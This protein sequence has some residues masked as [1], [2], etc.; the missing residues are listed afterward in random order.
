VSVAEADDVIEITD[1]RIEHGDYPEA[2]LRAI[3]DLERLAIRAHIYG[4]KDWGDAAREALKSKRPTSAEEAERI[5]DEHHR[6]HVASLYAPFGGLPDD[7]PPMGS[8]QWS[9]C[10]KSNAVIS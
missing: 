4:A 7:F 2:T 1:L 9:V 6:N 10:G 8:K 3:E 5:I